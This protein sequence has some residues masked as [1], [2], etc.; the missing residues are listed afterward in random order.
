M[1]L[2]RFQSDRRRFGLQQKGTF[3]GPDGQ[4]VGFR[5]ITHM[6][7]RT[8][9]CSMDVVLRRPKKTKASPSA[10]ASS[11]SEASAG[12]SSP[13][14]GPSSFPKPSRPGSPAPCS[15]AAASEVSCLSK[16]AETIV[17]TCPAP[18]PAAACCLH[19]LSTTESLSTWRML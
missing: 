11:T 12:G 1:H 10:Q 6:C 7:I 2:C 5:K 18:K 8:D 14:P 16:A 4:E 9:G 13:A 15:A 3:T 17:A 19:V